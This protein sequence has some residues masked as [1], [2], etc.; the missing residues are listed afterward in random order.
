MTKIIIHGLG[1]L[2]RSVCAAMD[3]QFTV[4]AAIEAAPTQTNDDFPVYMNVEQCTQNADVVVDC[5]VAHAVPA[6]LT[7]AVA[8]QLPLV[9]CTTALDDSTIDQ[10]NDAVAKIPIFLS[11]NMSLG[12]NLAAKLARTTAKA[13]DGKGFDIEIIERHHNQK[14]DAPSGTAVLLADSIT[15]AIG[16]QNMVYGRHG[17]RKRAPNEIGIHAIRGGTVVGEHTVIFAGHDEVIEIKHAALSRE[18]FARGALVA[19]KFITGKPPGLY[20]MDD[21]LE[22]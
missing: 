6:L 15:S 21:L 9:I 18:V 16:E 13:L 7:W 22:N 2:G 20:T 12:V 5:S 8:R 1:R 17:L 3:D 14:L 4:A 10:I 11:A 19:A